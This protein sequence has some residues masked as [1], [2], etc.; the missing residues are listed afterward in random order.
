MRIAHSM[1]MPHHLLTQ[2]RFY[3][4]NHFEFDIKYNGNRVIEV[5][6]TPHPMAVDISDVQPEMKVRF[7]Y[8]V[9][10]MPTQNQ[11]RW[12]RYRLHQINPVHLEVG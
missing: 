10:W 3:L 11:D 2:C 12:H 1:L 5:S 8:S 4:F 9:R 7:S 6:V